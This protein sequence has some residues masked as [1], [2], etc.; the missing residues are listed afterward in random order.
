MITI[1]KSCLLPEIA[2][3]NTLGTRTVTERDITDEEET[4]APYNFDKHVPSHK[5]SAKKVSPV[6]K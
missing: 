2:E 3:G 6:K 4:D 1:N 5:M